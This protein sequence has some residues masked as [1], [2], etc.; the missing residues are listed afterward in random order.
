MKW[1]LSGQVTLRSLGIKKE[2]TMLKKETRVIGETYLQLGKMDE[3]KIS[4]SSDSD[5]IAARQRGCALAERIGFDGTDLTLISTLISEMA[6]TL[7]RRALPG[8]ISM[9]ATEEA[10]NVGIAVV[11]SVCL[12][13]NASESKLSHLP[14]LLDQEL[15]LRAVPPIDGIKISFQQHEAILTM[16]KRDSGNRAVAPLMMGWRP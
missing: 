9:A 13:K 6:R 16:M 2:G 11:A 7:V 1:T 15:L 12:G 8:T 4:I 3:L 5:V 14:P 10:G